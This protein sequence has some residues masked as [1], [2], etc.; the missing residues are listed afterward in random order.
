MQQEYLSRARIAEA[1]QEEDWQNLHDEYKV[2]IHLIGEEQGRVANLEGELKALRASA[3]AQ[4][5][6]QGERIATLTRELEEHEAAQEKVLERIS[7]SLIQAKADSD[8]PNK[9]VRLP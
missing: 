3:A 2:L 1:G 5:V 4:A 6:E 9:R 7:A 8:G